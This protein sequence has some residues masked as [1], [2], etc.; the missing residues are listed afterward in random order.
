MNVLESMIVPV[1][2]VLAVALITVINLVSIPSD[3]IHLCHD[4]VDDIIIVSF[5]FSQHFYFILKL[6]QDICCIEVV[7][8]L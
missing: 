8:L 5:L 2:K 1:F 4:L 7:V 3:I 6:L